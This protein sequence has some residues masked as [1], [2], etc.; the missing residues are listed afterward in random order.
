MTTFA[1]HL[2]TIPFTTRS[3]EAVGFLPPMIRALGHLTFVLAVVADEDDTSMTDEDILAEL[4]H[5]I[6]HWNQI[7][8]P[9]TTSVAST[10]QVNELNRLLALAKTEWPDWEHKDRVKNIRDTANRIVGFTV[11]LDRELV[12]L[13]DSDA[14]SQL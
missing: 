13:R 2:A 5:A 3:Q 1:E 10:T 14:G 7:A 4:D 6:V 9:E 11:A 8:D 12:G